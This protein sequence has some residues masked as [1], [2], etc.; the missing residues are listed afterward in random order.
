ME[1]DLTALELRLHRL[2]TV[3]GESSCQRNLLKE[4]KAVQKALRETVPDEMAAAYKTVALLSSVGTLPATRAA[5][6]EK[7]SLLE[8]T[9]D[10]AETYVT[11]FDAL[12]HV[13]DKPLDL[14]QLD[15]GAL[16]TLESSVCDVSNDIAEEERNVD[17]LLMEF[18]SVTEK[19][20]DAMLHMAHHLQ[21]RTSPEKEPT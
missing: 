11:E 16:A 5:R 7:L 12:Q 17:A 1:T 13:L 15:R 2:E 14:G 19:L 8:T 6:V 18:N 4:L 21:S 10:Q 3:V 9:L 20:N